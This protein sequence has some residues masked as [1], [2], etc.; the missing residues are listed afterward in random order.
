M[1]CT[2]FPDLLIQQRQIRYLRRTNK[3][4]IPIPKKIPLFYSQISFSTKQGSLLN[5]ITLHIITCAVEL[6]NDA[7]R[8]NYVIFIS[9]CV[10]FLLITSSLRHLMLLQKFSHYVNKAAVYHYAHYLATS[11]LNYI[12]LY[13][14]FGN[15]AFALNYINDRYS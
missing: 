8:L 6:T 11:H 14:L 13:V 7:V 15:V 5:Q 4:I 12:T 1:F 9:L 2:Q 10:L 3:K